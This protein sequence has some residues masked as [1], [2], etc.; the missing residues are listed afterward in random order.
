MDKGCHVLFGCLEN[1]E[2]ILLWET[3][4]GGLALNQ[5]LERTILK[6]THYVLKV[7]FLKVS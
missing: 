5:F 4:N 2:T 6:Q 3:T 1:E 7:T